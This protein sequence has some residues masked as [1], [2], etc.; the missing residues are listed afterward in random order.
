MIK[1][2]WLTEKFSPYD[3]HSRK[4]KRKLVGINTKYQKIQV[5]DTY[6]L[7]RCLVLDQEMQ[8]AQFDEYIYHEALVHPALIMHKNPKEILVMGGGE[9]ATLREILKHRTVKKITML[10]IDRQVIDFAKKYLGVWNRGA[11]SDKR[12]NLIIT[13]AKKYI[14]NE[15]KKFDVIISDLCSPIKHGPAYQLYTLEFYKILKTRLKE[16]GIFILQAG[17]ANLLQIKLFSLLFSTLKR[18]FKEII[19]FYEYIP[20]FD[21]PWAFIICL[22]K[23]ESL[24]KKEI[25]ERIKRRIKG[26]L[27]FYDETTHKRIF[28]LPK[29]IRM[30]LEKEKEIITIKRPYFFYK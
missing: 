5:L 18:V 7:G 22:N 2:Y 8:S 27:R 12:L 23:K 9:G 17:S 20:S 25:K 15:D 29:N 16:D 30:I 4:I 19:S 13:D 11:F 6:S 26:N 24:S 1:S 21:V 10:D 28:Y 14:E 3:K